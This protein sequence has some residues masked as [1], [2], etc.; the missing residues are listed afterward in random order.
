[1]YFKFLIGIHDANYNLICA[2]IVDPHNPAEIRV[3]NALY[4]YYISKVIEL[5]DTVWM[6]LR[7]KDRQISFLHLLHHSAIV[8]F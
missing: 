6:V 4:W 5:F 2:E 3:M 7:K 8:N 1:L